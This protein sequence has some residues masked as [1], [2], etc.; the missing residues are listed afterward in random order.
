MPEY[1]DMKLVQGCRSVGAMF[2]TVLGSNRMA[3]WESLM[4]SDREKNFPFH[5]VGQWQSRALRNRLHTFAYFFAW[6]QHILPLAPARSAFTEHSEQG[7]SPT[8]IPGLHVVLTAILFAL[9]KWSPRWVKI[10][11]KS[12]TIFSLLWQGGTPLRHTGIFK[13]KSFLIRFIVLSRRMDPGAAKGSSGL[14]SITWSLNR[15]AA[16][17]AS[18]HCFK[19][20]LNPASCMRHLRCA[21]LEQICQQNKRAGTNLSLFQQQ[22]C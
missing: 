19:S 10:P 13:F 14:F 9:A 8:V 2:L 1:L 22:R 5:F 17:P 21:L 11:P 4:A 20:H 3:A 6:L 15:E 7:D 16:F 18:A 12:G